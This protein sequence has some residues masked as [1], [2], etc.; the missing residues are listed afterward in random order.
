MK[1]GERR[2][3]APRGGAPAVEQR[4]G[5]RGSAGGGGS[6]GA[7]G[8]GQFYHRGC[9]DGAIFRPSLHAFAD[10]CAYIDSIR[11]EAEAYG[12]ILIRPPAGWSPPSRWPA[13]SRSPHK[14]LVTNQVLGKL[15]QGA[16]FE[17][18]RRYTAAEYKT[19][20]DKSKG[21]WGFPHAAGEAHGGGPALPPTGSGDYPLRGATAAISAGSASIEA[22]YWEVLHGRRGRPGAGEG[23]EE[24]IVVEYAND[25]D[26]RACG[27][28]FPTRPLPSPFHVPAG[29]EGGG[30]GGGWVS[31]HDT[32]VPDFA[33]PAYYAETGW[34]LTNLPFLRGSLLRHLHEEV[35][36]LNV[37]WLYYGSL[38]T[39]F[40]WHIEDNWAYSI[41]YMHEGEGKV[42]YG[43]P[44]SSAAQFEELAARM[45][46]EAVARREEAEGEG[47][48][49]PS[50]RKNSRSR[51][52]ELSG[53]GKDAL[54]NITTMLD[55]ARLTAEGVPV[56]RL[57]QCPGDFVLTFPRAYH[58]GFSLGWTMAEAV[59][60]ASAD[61]LEWGA[62]ACARY[63]DTRR[64]CR[65][66]AFAHEAL[67]LGMG[68]DAA[69]VPTHQL[70]PLI[71]QLVR[72]RDEETRARA[73]LTPC[74]PSEMLR[75]TSD[76]DVR[77]ECVRCKRL[78]HLSALAC[79][80]CASA[81]RRVSCLAHGADLCRC[82]G[83][84]KVLAVWWSPHNVER[85][86]EGVRAE[87]GRREAVT[88]PSAAKRPRGGRG[89]EES[90]VDSDVEVIESRFET[91]EPPSPRP[92]DSSGP[93]PPRGRPRKS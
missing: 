80:T 53:E 85:V 49:G 64:P 52:A 7:A 82:P 84:R 1:G 86:L 32:V 28:G 58:A 24:D 51:A 43:V 9:K 41:N 20:A 31:P 57:V 3:D 92:S 65:P 6:R 26:T 23:G 14:H 62:A 46:A 81:Q 16:P 76:A 90:V 74:L 69:K 75:V 45:T 88:P 33:S 89:P 34:N 12:V 11:E 66:P 35:N 78:C 5:D 61:W 72:M 73:S 67:V 10:P 17:Y 50:P 71:T 18:G 70:A 55:P 56:Q 30:G 59:N 13:L 27:S 44:S 8:G 37:P 2:G 54:Y 36:G 47:A 38:F 68:A 93:R 60:F 91:V 15:L 39:T 83:E 40:S 21:A 42:W 25:Q 4:G 87:A 79:R 77:R 19:K 22:A 48:G 63:C 29:G